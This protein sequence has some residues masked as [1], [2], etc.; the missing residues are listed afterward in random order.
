MNAVKLFS[1]LFDHLSP[2]EI[3]LSEYTDVLDRMQRAGEIVAVEYTLAHMPYRVKTMY[4]PKG[5]VLK[6]LK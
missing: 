3:L 2:E 5:T 6:V 4:F 1:C